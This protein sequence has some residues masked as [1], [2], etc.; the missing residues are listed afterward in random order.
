MS[1]YQLHAATWARPEGEPVW[2]MLVGQFTSLDPSPKSFVP[3]YHTLHVM[4]GGSATLITPRGDFQIDG[5]SV[6]C[7]WPGYEWSF[8]EREPIQ[9]YFLK[10][11]GPHL[12]NLLQ[13]LNLNL[14]TPVIENVNTLAIHPLLKNLKDIHRDLEKRDPYQCKSIFNE[15]CYLIRKEKIILQNSP[16][17][18]LLKEAKTLVSC[19]IDTTAL[20]VNRIAS[21]LHTSK[22]TLLRLFKKELGVTPNQYIQQERLKL[23]KCHLNDGKKLHFIASAC[24]FSSVNYLITFFKHHEGLTPDAWR[25]QRNVDLAV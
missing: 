12:N 1:V 20:D 18:E 24:G 7:S 11:V 3:P 4:V 6:F 21:E 15:I 9:L 14:K 25:K 8:K 19:L 5:N 16:H 2:P 17:V 22:S 10:V 23:I 13:D